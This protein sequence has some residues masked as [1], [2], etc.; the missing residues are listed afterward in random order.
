MS[1]M[2]VLSVE[3]LTCIG[4]QSRREVLGAI[5]ALRRATAAEVGSHLG[6]PAS[7]VTYHIRRLVEANL[8]TE[9][10]RRP[11]GHKPEAVYGMTYTKLQLPQ[12]EPGSVAREVQTRTVASGLRAM[13]RGFEA[14]SASHGSLPYVVRATLRL[15]SEDLEAFLELVDA[16]VKFADERRDQSAE[17]YDWSAVGFHRT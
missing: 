9:L 2:H 12:A 6:R 14:A 13:V 5:S 7:S 10:E 3:Q 4:N 8:V 17:V 16:A 15:K 1:E 11:T